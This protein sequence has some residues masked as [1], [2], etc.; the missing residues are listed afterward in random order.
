[1]IYLSLARI[2]F[3][4]HIYQP[5]IIFVR[6]RAEGLNVNAPKCDF[7]L[8]DIP[9]L[10]CVITREGIK[11]DPKKVQGIMNIRK[12]DTTTESRLIIGMLQYYRDIWPRQSH[13][14]D[15]L[16]EAASNHKSR[17]VLWNDALEVLL[18]N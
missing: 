1:M 7:G 18:K 4:N 15:P 6:L 8:K 11:P 17:K 3:K 5:R 9:Y 10:S 13:V 12:P 2:A 14:L 16:T